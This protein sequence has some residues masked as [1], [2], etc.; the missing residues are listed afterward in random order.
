MPAREKICADL[1]C[2]LRLP[3]VSVLLAKVTKPDGSTQPVALS[4]YSLA[5]NHLSWF[6]LQRQNLEFRVIAEVIDYFANHMTV[7]AGMW[8]FDTWI[9]NRDRTDR[10]IMVGYSP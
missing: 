2:L 10:N 7:T 4:K 5:R 6:R 3:V 8:V 9:Q 1:G